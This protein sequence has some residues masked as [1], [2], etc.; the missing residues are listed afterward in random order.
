MC[1][2]SVATSSTNRELQIVMIYLRI[3]QADQSENIVFMKKIS[4]FEVRKPTGCA[5]TSKNSMWAWG[6]QSVYKTHLKFEL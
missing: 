4:K 5:A 3:I 1:V 6:S 2:I